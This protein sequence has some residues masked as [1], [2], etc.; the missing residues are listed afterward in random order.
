MALDIEAASLL[1]AQDRFFEIILAPEFAPDA[2]E[3]LKARWKNVR[4]LR[5]GPLG[6]QAGRLDI[7]PIP[8]GLLAQTHDDTPPDQAHWTHAAGPA[9][10]AALLESAGLVEVA[11]RALSSNAVAIGGPVESNGCAL[12]GSGAGQMER[13]ASCQL[14]VAKAGQRARGAVAVSDAFFPFPDGPAVLIDAGISMLVHPGGSKRDSE[15]FEL[16]NQRGITCM[17]TG[18]RR[19]RH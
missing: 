4:L 11:V 16:C 2:L 3:L 13:V 12:F 6:V 1:A 18:V 8:G 5:T 17:T 7:R 19:F 15:T 9:P 14:A 10:D